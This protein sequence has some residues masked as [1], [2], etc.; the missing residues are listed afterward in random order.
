MLTFFL[1]LFKQIEALDMDGCLI[2]DLELDFILPGHSNIEI[3]K[4]GRDSGVTIHNLH[5]YISLV[6]HWFLNEGVNRQF[7]ALREGLFVFS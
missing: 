6:T 7:E 2:C 5:Q 4:G 1:K 3:K